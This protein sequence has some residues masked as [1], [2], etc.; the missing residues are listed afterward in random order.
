MLNGT[1][2]EPDVLDPELFRLTMAVVAEMDAKVAEYLTNPSAYA[3]RRRRRDVTRFASGWPNVGSELASSS[4]EA[5]AYGDL[6]SQD[7]D[8]IHPITFDDITSMAELFTYASSEPSIRDRVQLSNSDESRQDLVKRLFR[9][10]VTSLPTSIYDRAKATGIAVNDASVIDLYREREMAWLAPELPYQLVVPL[11]LTNL[12]IDDDQF[13]IDS[14]TRIETLSD[15]VLRAMAVDYDVSGVPGVLAVAATSAVVVDMPPMPNSGPGPRLISQD[16]PPDTT[17]VDTV[18]DALRVLTSTTT[19]WARVFQ[20]PVGWADLWHNDLPALTHVYT[21]RKYPAVF[22]D[23]GWLRPGDKIARSTIE[24]LPEVITAL[25]A[26][27]SSS[28]TRLAM[29]RLSI[30]QVRDTPDDQTVDACIGLEALLGQTDSELSYRISLRTAALLSSRPTE[31]F[32]P[33]IAFAM[34]RKVYNRRSELVHGSTKEKHATF[35]APDHPYVQEIP[36]NSIAMML[37]RE[38]LHERLLRA[39]SWTVEDLDALVL[40]RLTPAGSPETDV[41]GIAQPKD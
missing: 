30:G 24:R 3:P 9:Y 28:P 7:R 31:P 15:S 1:V 14:N 26:A 41:K 25:E 6:L 29:R 34:T 40:N 16:L 37:L 10:E 5:I 2:E 27:P 33:S 12:E 32:D 19:G 39:D 8:A 35:K 21:A 36:T 18:C 23:Y 20:R 22:D 11:I 13:R 38:V 17:K 4:T